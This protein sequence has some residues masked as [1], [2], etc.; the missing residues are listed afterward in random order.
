MRNLRY[1]TSIILAT[2]FS[3]TPEYPEKS[4]QEAARKYLEDSVITSRVK[5]AIADEPDLESLAI[6]VETYKATVQLSGFISAQCDISKVVKIARNVQ[7]VE[8]VR[9]NLQVRQ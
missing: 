9:N 1:F 5:S 8:A 3:A 4:K 6:N 7:G 2:G